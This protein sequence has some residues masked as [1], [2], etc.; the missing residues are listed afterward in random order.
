MAC[1]RNSKDGQV[2]GNMMDHIQL[3]TLD[4]SNH[5]WEETIEIKNIY[6]GKE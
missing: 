1:H 6:Q 4:E 5:E 3:E 2:S